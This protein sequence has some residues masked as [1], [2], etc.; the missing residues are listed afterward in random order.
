MNIIS[1]LFII[2]LIITIGLGTINLI[3]T[4]SSNKGSLI[5]GD[6]T[7]KIPGKIPKIIPF[8][9]PI[10]FPDITTPSITTSTTP[11]TPP[12]TPHVLTPV[13][14]GPIQINGVFCSTPGCRRALNTD[15]GITTMDLF[16]IPDTG[17]LMDFSFTAGYQINS[18]ESI[19]NPFYIEIINELDGSIY[20]TDYYFGNVS[21]GTTTFNISPNIEVN[22]NDQVRITVISHSDG[23]YTKIINPVIN[24]TIGI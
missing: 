18:D 8:I 22:K 20:K 4:D 9:F 7:G 10:I 6:N 17:I 11:P 1:I 21:A 16:K 15:T 19:Q 14:F 5:T 3:S 23:N 12:T 13:N 24:L 2:L